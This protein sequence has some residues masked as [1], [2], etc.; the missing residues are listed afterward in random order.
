MLNEECGSI[1]C[2]KSIKFG[3]DVYPKNGW[4]VFIAGGPGASKSTTIKNQLM[5]DAVV[6]DC[7]KILNYYIKYLQQM[8]NEKKLSQTEINEI[9]KIFEN[10]SMDVSNPRI[11]TILYKINDDKSFFVKKFLAFVKAHNEY[12]E[13]IIIDSTGNNSD[14]LNNTAI[15]LK[16]MGYKT[17]FIWV[18]SNIKEAIRRNVSRKRIVDIEYLITVHKNLLTVVP[19]ILKSNNFDE[20]W[21]IF[22]NNISDFSATFNKKYSNTAVKLN[23]TN[24]GFEIPIKLKRRIITQMDKEHLDSGDGE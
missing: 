18:V 16:N 2:D 7:D 6:L 15:L 4:A 1:L 5:I 3:D 22:S 21:I 17:S 14:A 8:I 20:A 24:D 11:N 9:N 13:N 19:A 23:K 12:L 10:L